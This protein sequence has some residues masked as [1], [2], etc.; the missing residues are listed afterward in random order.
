MSSKRSWRRRTS[1]ARDSSVGFSS[2]AVLL[3]GF[4]SVFD[5]I[6]DDQV[7]FQHEEHPE[8]THPEPERRRTEIG[9]EELVEKVRLPPLHQVLLALY[10]FQPGSRV[11]E[12]FAQLFKV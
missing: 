8:A 6:H 10:S 12:G 11:C 4:L 7:A 2:V 5:S 3:I 9:E 1:A